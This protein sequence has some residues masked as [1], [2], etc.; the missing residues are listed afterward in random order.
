MNLQEHG[1]GNWKGG[2]FETRSDH[3]D[4]ANAW[5]QLEQGQIGYFE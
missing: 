5:G 2:L 3:H 4:L 1:S